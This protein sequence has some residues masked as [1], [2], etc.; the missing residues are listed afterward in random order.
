MTKIDIKTA[1]S[2]HE[3]DAGLWDELSIDKPFQ[4]HGWYGYGEQV[5]AD[6]PPVYL[7]AFSN[8]ALIARACLWL[9]GNEPVPKTLGPVRN[10]AVTMLKRWPLLICRSPLSYT[11][12]LVFANNMSQPEVLSAFSEA[13]LYESNV[14]RASFVIFDY[15]SKAIANEWNHYFSV[16]STPNPGT[17]MENH[18]GTMDEYLMSAGKKNRQH[19]KRVLREAERMGIKIER[20]LNVENPDVALQLIRNVER[21]HGALPNPWAGRMLENIP[22]VNGSFLTAKIDNQLVGCGLALEDNSAQMTSSLGLA[23]NVPYVYFM[24]LYESLNMAFEHNVRLLRWGSG[25]YDVK[26]RLGFTLED[27]D[28][29]AF[30]ATSPYLQ[31]VVRWLT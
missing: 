26:L 30:A 28:F 18:W 10:I 12:G 25:A 14:R 7:L 24:L 11:T 2:I 9:V 27:N 3:I 1:S 17:H 20:H 15:Q 19:Y 13:A 21:R 22:M 29:L 31:K 23:E 6:C 5:M 8:G 16:I 4:S